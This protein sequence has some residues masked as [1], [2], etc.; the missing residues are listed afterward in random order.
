MEKKREQDLSVLE[1]LRLHRE[2]HLPHPVPADEQEKPLDK[3]KEPPRPRRPDLAL[4]TPDAVFTVVKLRVCFRE[5]AQLMKDRTVST[6]KAIIGTVNSLAQT[7]H[8]S[9]CRTKFFF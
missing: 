1:V 5:L 4:S 6:V 9:S 7:R 2:F 3:V 8:L